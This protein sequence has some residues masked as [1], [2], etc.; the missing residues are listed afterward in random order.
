[1]FL[2]LVECKVDVFVLGIKNII[3]GGYELKDGIKVFLVV[4][5]I[6]KGKK[7]IVVLVIYCMVKK[8]GDEVV[9]KEVYIIL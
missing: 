7:V 1:M 9:V 5:K 8:E 2:L 4:E 3:E 6:E